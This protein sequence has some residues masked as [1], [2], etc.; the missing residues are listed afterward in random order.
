[1]PAL[2]ILLSTA[3][4]LGE[5]IFIKRYNTRHSQG[6]FVFTALISFFS[7]LFF[8]VTDQ[9]GF[10]LPA[11][12]WWYGLA[13]GVLYCSASFATYLAF[14]FGSY[15]MTMLILSY[16][17]VFSIGYG[18]IFLK[19]S[20]TI[21]TYAG[22]AL[23][24][25][26]LYLL[27]AAKKEEKE[28]TKFSFKWLICITVAAIGNGMFSVV[29]RMQQL[30]FDNTVNNEFMV[31][32]LTFSTLTLLT[33]GVWRNRKDFSYVLRHGLLWTAG[34]GVSNGMTNSMVVFLHT[35][36]PISIS[37]PIRVAVKVVASFLLSVFL[38][39]ERFEKRQIVG[40]MLGMLAL[41]LLNIK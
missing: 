24:L 39:R 38:Y 1:M 20:A 18:L 6:G 21:F 41:I 15:A 19:E 16:S 29:Q 40:A 11:D 12:L 22:L 7:M 5:S 35:L 2:L 31:M 23:V 33:V 25:A 32:A 3:T 37:S 10:L 4:H 8:L 27:R 9:N 30:R 28:K 13:S 34:A 36:M 14:Q 26:S 17:I